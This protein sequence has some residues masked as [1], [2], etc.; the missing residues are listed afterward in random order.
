MRRV[1]I[2]AIVCSAILV[3][4]ASAATFDLQTATVADIQAAMD[5]GA[6]TSEK[7]VQLYL[8][9]APWTPSAN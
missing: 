3:R 7:L 5:A 2:S 1:C 6:L 4:A 8:N 9:H